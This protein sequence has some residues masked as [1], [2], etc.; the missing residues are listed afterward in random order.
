[1]FY[2]LFSILHSIFFILPSNNLASDIYI[3]L[4][5]IL[6]EAGAR[7]QTLIRLR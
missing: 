7:G 4:Y 1:M 5:I 2:M 6:C 3:Y